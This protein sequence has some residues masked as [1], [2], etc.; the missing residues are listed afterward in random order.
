ML[1]SFLLM[2]AAFFR[3]SSAQKARSVGRVSSGAAQR[4]GPL[5][6]DLCSGLLLCALCSVLCALRPGTCALGFCSVL[7]ALC[8]VP[9]ALG[10]A[11]WA[12]AQGPLKDSLLLWAVPEPCENLL[13]LWAMQESPL[14][15][16]AK[17]ESPAA[18]GHAH[19]CT[20]GQSGRVGTLT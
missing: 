9:C 7:C 18:L 19:G 17:R 12:S 13:L 8:S 14:V 11:L 16:W 6:W 2:L 1:P 10:P 3:T 4:G 20:G 15:L 5:P